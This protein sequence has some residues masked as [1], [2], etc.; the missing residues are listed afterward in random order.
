MMLLELLSEFGPFLAQHI[1]KYGN[2]DSGFTLYLSSTICEE[3]IN[4]MA[5]KS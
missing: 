2:S 5:K 4:L 3:I 1:S